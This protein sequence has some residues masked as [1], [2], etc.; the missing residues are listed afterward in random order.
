MRGSA[1]RPKQRY[2]GFRRHSCESARCFFCSYIYLLMVAFNQEKRREQSSRTVSSYF[3]IQ[4]VITT[5]IIIIFFEEKRAE[6][7]TII[8]IYFEAGS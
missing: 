2:L 7:L 6:D 3:S 1:D 5:I 8:W 4:F